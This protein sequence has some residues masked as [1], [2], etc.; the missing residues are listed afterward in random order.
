MRLGIFGLALVVLAGPAVLEAQQTGK[1]PAIGYLMERRFSGLP[2][3]AKR[4][5]PPVT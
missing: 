5:R 3:S 2:C 4:I 1:V